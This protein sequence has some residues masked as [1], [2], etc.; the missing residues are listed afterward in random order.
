MKEIKS[1]GD[2]KRKNLVWQGN[3]HPANVPKIA[4]G[5]DELDEKLQGGIP[6]QGVMLIQ[7]IL[8]IGELRMLMPYLKK[9]TIASKKLTV[10]I[11]PPMKINGEMLQ[12]Y[13]IPL[14]D[15]LVITPNSPQHALWSA[16]Q[17]LKSGACHSVL[18]WHQDVSLAQG[19]RLQ[20]CA[21][22]GQALQV[23]FNTNVRQTV[24]LPVSL[25]MQLAP[26]K[27]GLQVNVRKHQGH[28]V[29]APFKL[30]M[31]QQWPELTLNQPTNNVI[32]IYR[33]S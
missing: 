19:K 5:Y 30:N 13:G 23:I 21:K 24:S 9:R 28:W 11:A 6:E 3:Y 18:L 10:F 16:E 22:K 26:N 33:A 14:D 32:P 15:I 1:L 8:G 17:C 25:T 31:H 7:S 27:T 12:H 20:L 29:P 4:S 2:L